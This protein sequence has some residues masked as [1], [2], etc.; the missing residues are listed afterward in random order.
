MTIIDETTAKLLFRV[1]DGDSGGSNSN[2]ADMLAKRIVAAL[3][4]QC[5]RTSTSSA[6]V[7]S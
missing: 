3:P 1:S 7:A 5:S 6:A 4:A 2:V